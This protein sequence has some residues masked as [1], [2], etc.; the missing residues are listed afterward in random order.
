MANVAQKI[1]KR[2]YPPSNML[3]FL[4]RKVMKPSSRQRISKLIAGR[5]QRAVPRAFSSANEGYAQSLDIEGFVMLPNLLSPTQIQDVFAYL[6]DKQCTDRWK[7]ESGQ[8][9]IAKA[10]ANCHTADYDQST[11]VKCPHLLEAANNPL[12][13][14]IVSKLLR[15]KPTLSSMGLWW[16]LSGHDAPEQAE[17]FHRDVDEWHFIKFFVYLTDVTEDS[18]PHVF[19]KGSQREAKLLPIR[20]YT[21]TEIESTFGP[22]RVI[23]FTGPAGTNF[24]ENTFGFHKGQ[25]AKSANRLVFQSQYS[26]LPIHLY[27]YN[28]IQIEPARGSGFDPYINRLYVKA[29]GI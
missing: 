17:N 27:K 24:L 7:P 1:I 2:V 20:R 14:D 5:L 23:R 22:D 4:Q 29:A 15:C 21:D 26:L 9:D 18:G 10:P 25:M 16:S 28:P 8:F 19:V 12:V 3:F 11:V 6:G 13:L